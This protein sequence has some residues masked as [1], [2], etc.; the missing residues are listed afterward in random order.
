[1]NLQK[2]YGEDGYKNLE[3]DE[4]DNVFPP[5]FKLIVKKEADNAAVIDLDFKICRKTKNKE[6]EYWILYIPDIGQQ[7]QG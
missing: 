3:K 4:N 6:D 7:L 2:W 1:M 5:R